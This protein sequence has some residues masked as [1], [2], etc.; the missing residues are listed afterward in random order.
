MLKFV[1]ISIILT[2]VAIHFSTWVYVPNSAMRKIKQQDDSSS[3][4]IDYFHYI[5]NMD[6]SRLWNTQL[7][8][9][10]NRH[11]ACLYF[12]NNFALYT[13]IYSTSTCSIVL[14]LF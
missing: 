2:F 8:Y 1:K 9:P 13:I 5:N 4:A 3:S 10:T 6:K 11:G 7:Y 14:Y 12:C